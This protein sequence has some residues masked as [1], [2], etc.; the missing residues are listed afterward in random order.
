MERL[1]NGT[2]EPSIKIEDLQ[3]NAEWEY[4]DPVD[5][6]IEPPA[7]D[8]PNYRNFKYQLSQSKNLNPE[9]GTY[10]P[11]SIRS[12]NIWISMD[13][14]LY[15][16]DRFED[17]P[18]SMRAKSVLFF[19]DAKNV[20]S[21]CRLAINFLFNFCKDVGEIESWTLFVLRDY[22]IALHHIIKTACKGGF[23]PKSLCQ[24]IQLSKTLVLISVLKLVLGVL[25]LQPI[26]NKKPPIGFDLTSGFSI[27]A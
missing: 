11:D 21:H 12:R 10:V 20:E 16:Y 22:F 19:R 26:D 4:D 23:M 27:C 5:V 13:H 25:K 15:A 8:H 7:E 24:F 1:W 3:P 14:Y 18:T 2:Y 6:D 9:A 17:D